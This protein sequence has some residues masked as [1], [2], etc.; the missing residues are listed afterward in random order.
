LQMLGENVLVVDACPDNLLRLS[1]NVDFTHRQGWARAM[2]DGQD[3]RDAGLRYTSQ[4]DLLPFGQLSIEEQENP[5]HWQTRLSDI[6]TGLQQLKAS[7]R[8]QWI[9]IDLP[10]DASQITHQLLSLCDHSLAIVNVDANCHIRLHQQA[11]PDGAHILINDFRIGSQVQDDIYQ[12]WLQSQRRLLPMLIHR[13]E[14]MAECLAAKQ[15][16]GEYRSDALAAEE[17]LTLANWCLLNYSGLK[18]PVG[19]AS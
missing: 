16:V 6:C 15:P 13:D 3:W 17:I 2:L 11:L 5:Q 12:L 9:L 18:M 19:S 7:G 14:A 1:F 4:L 8:Y 10:R